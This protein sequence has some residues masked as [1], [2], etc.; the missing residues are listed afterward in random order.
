MFQIH[1]HG[2]LIVQLTKLYHEGDL[3]TIQSYIA[4]WE[5]KT[6]KLDFTHLPLVEQVHI[7]FAKGIKAALSFEPETACENLIKATLLIPNEQTM[8]AVSEILSDPEY[9][10]GFFLNSLIALQN[11][12]RTGT[13]PSYLSFNSNT[14]AEHKYQ[15]YLKRV[16]Q[17]KVLFRCERSIN[18]LQGNFFL[19]QFFH[20]L[21]G[22]VRF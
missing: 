15:S 12:S 1:D 19:V 8:S 7:L 21:T 13:L 11:W 4:S 10:Y 9:R 5:N 14:L 3:T 22:F 16:T 18:K 6:G 2:L 20:K 17:V